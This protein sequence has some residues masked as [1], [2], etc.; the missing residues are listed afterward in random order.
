MWCTSCQDLSRLGR[1]MKRMVLVDD[2][3]LAFLRQPD[4]GIP[5]FNFRCGPGR[6]AYV[7]CACSGSYCLL[8]SLRSP[9]KNVQDGLHVVRTPQQGMPEGGRPA[10]WRCADVQRRCG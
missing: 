10:D 3:P 5:I 9:G 4:N 1:D 2:T 7:S 8:A 6:T